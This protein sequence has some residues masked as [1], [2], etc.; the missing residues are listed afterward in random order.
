MHIAVD[1]FPLFLLLG[2]VTCVIANVVVMIP[3]VVSVFRGFGKDPVWSSPKALS[4][5][6]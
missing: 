1:G 5:P 4:V 3:V 2:S 6:S